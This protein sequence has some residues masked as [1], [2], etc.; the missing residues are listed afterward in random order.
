[1]LVAQNA[2]VL[3]DVPEDQFLLSDRVGVETTV[4]PSSIGTWISTYGV[5]P[6]TD[7]EDRGKVQ[8]MRVCE[9]DHH[10]GTEDDVTGHPAW[11]GCIFLLNTIRPHWLIQNDLVW[12]Q[13]PS[14]KAEDVR[15]KRWV[16]YYETYDIVNGDVDSFM[17]WVDEFIKRYGAT[18]YT[19]SW[20][21]EEWFRKQVLDMEAKDKLKKAREIALEKGWIW[22]PREKGWYSWRNSDTPQPKFG[23]FPT[24]DTCLFDLLERLNG[25]YTRRE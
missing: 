12:L 13:D 17:A 7:P 2:R 23:P 19:F 15:L 25:T 22:S 21:I 20:L 1:M 11:Q 18:T 3:P 9:G 4:S 14:L 24:E 8:L 5:A 16:A 6:H 10:I